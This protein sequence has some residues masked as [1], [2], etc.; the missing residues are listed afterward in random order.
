M[1]IIFE[2]RIQ[3]LVIDLNGFALGW[4]GMTMLSS[5]CPFAE[6][7]DFGV[8]LLVNSWFPLQC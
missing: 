2:S 3:E 1:G 6:T 7:V 4:L 5:A 8:N